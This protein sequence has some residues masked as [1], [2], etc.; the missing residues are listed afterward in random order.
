MKASL[1]AL[2][3]F[4]LTAATTLQAGDWVSL[5]DGKSLAGWTNFKGEK[6]TTEGWQ[7]EGDALHLK[8]K[9]G[10]IISEKEYSE[11]E[12]EWEWKIAEGGNNGLKYWVN[13]ISNQQLG[14]EYQMIDDVKHPDAKKKGNHDTASFYDILPI[15]QDKPVKAAGEWNTSKVVSKGGKLEHWLNGKLVGTADTASEAWKQGVAAS[16]FGKYPGFAPGKGR[17]MLTDHGDETWF[18]NI[19]IKE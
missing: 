8:G 9:G 17:I 7:I 12:L 16:K 15:S 1:T 5:F 10:N 19:R 14:V 2:L 6:I 3:L 4:T 13:P 11:F 18:R